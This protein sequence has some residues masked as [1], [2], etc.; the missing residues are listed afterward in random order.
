MTNRNFETEATG[1]RAG[2]WYPY[3]LVVTT[4]LDHRI[5]GRSNLQYPALATSPVLTLLQTH[6]AKSILLEMRDG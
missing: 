4:Y 3:S 1:P 6:C 5:P 2:S